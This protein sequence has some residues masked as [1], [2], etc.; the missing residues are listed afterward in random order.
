MQRSMTWLIRVKDL[1]FEVQVNKGAERT[2]IG[3][4]GTDTGGI[5]TETFEVLPGVEQVLRIQRPYKL[6]SRD[7]KRNNTVVK[8]GNI[9]IGGEKAGD[10]G[11]TLLC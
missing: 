7:F 5:D 9:E 3:V 11:W 6:A 1:G 10:D 8:V 4:F 2:V